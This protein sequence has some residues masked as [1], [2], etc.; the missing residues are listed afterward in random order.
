MSQLIDRRNLE[1]VLYEM[2]RA[3]ELCQHPEYSMHDRETFDAVID[4]A[5]QLAGEYFLNHAAKADE[6]EPAFEGGSVAIIPEIGEAL[7]A[8]YAAGFGSMGFKESI[9]GM[10]LPWIVAQACLAIFMSANVSTAAYALLTGAAANLLEAFG[11]DEQKG[12]FL[13]AMLTG[14]CYGTMCLSE[15]QAGSSLADIRTRA[16]ATT[17]G[18]YLIDGTKMWIS[19]GDHQLSENIVHFVLARVPDGPP[20]VKGI[21]LFLVPKYLPA[22]GAGAGQ[23]NDV[24]LAGINHKMGYRGIVNTVLNFGEKGR[25]V[26]YLIGEPNMGL[27]Y[28]FHM[29]NE[30]R[31]GVGMGATALGYAGYLTS[32]EYA[33]ERP[34]GRLPGNNDPSSSPVRIIEHADV[35]RLLL[36]QKAYVE[37]AFALV[38]YCARLVDRKRMARSGDTDQLDLLL[39][40][41]TPIA[42][43]WPSECCLEANKHAIQ[44]LGGY[45]YSR[46][47]PVERLY[48]DNRLNIIH[49]GTHGIQAI[50]LL[51]RKVTQAGGLAFK[52][53]IAE[54]SQTIANARETDTLTP[55]VEALSARC[56][57][58]KAT[59]DTLVERLASGERAIALANA[60]LYLDAFGH[61]VV[62][63]MWL[64][65]AIVAEDRMQSC[66]VHDQHFYTGKLSAC[67]YFYR[68]ELP[69]VDA[70]LDL[71][72][73][74]DD[75]CLRIPADAF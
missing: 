67:Q 15:P 65:Q 23:L 61:I 22:G 75:T 28:M 42:K 18:H 50:D 64:E 27:R 74:L 47:Y 34:Q 66:G 70:A 41:L 14:R 51:G 49:E 3:D 5:E 53:L 30:A 10:G 55:F 21:S 54:I 7:D 40:V 59:T 52:C 63:W 71:L 48:R 60:T 68:Y 33:R 26:G 6:Q 4:A 9:G 29:M 25:C 62:A 20:G 39:D 69:R 37:G 56:E 1:F 44:V 58:L 36:A 35:K 12:W 16:V 13:E 38:L 17:E 31:I 24:A 2:L 8:F 73:T 32:L 57:V 19:G 45:G 46:E 11:T 43:S 72:G